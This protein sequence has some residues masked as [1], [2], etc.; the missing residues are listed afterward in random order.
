MSSPFYNQIDF[1]DCGATCIKIISKLFGKTLNIQHLR[2]F[3]ETTRGGASLLG[4][5]EASEKLGFPFIA[6][7]KTPA[8]NSG[9]IKVG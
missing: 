8:Q 6:K 2:D 7:L 9:K 4:L 1:K 3:T 5:S